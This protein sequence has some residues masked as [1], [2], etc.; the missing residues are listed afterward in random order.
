MTEDKEFS[1]SINAYINSGAYIKQIDK[2]MNIYVVSNEGI[3]PFDKEVPELIEI[4][5]MKQ[6]SKKVYTPVKVVTDD[7]GNWYVIPNNLMDTFYKD[8]FD[9]DKVDSG[10]FDVVWGKYR[11]GG[12]LNL[13]QL[14]AIT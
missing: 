4:K 14:Y 13:I 12:N 1:E 9:V 6:V 5:D 10:D 7:S 3:E 2:D 11:T 8:L